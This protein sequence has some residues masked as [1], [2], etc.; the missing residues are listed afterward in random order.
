MKAIF[1]YSTLAFFVGF[2]PILCEHLVPF[3]K[4]TP[5]PPA[6][7]CVQWVV[8]ILL[9]ASSGVTM[10]WSL[11]SRLVTDKQDEIKANG[12]GNGNP[13]PPTPVPVIPPPVNP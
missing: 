12:N 5:L 13:P 10:V 4:G 7:T 9:G 6:P 11:H 8:F 2:L 1:G 3:T